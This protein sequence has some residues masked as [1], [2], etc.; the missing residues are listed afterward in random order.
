YKSYHILG[1]PSEFY[2][3]YWHDSK[4]GVASY[5]S[6]DAKRGRKI[7]MWGL[8]RQGMIWEDLLTDKPAGQYVEIQAGR[9]FNQCRGESSFTPFKDRE[10][11]P[12]S[13]DLWT[14]YWMPVLDTGGFNAVS[15]A[16]SMNV[17]VGQN[18]VD[19]AI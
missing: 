6:M 5:L 9:L 4:Y 7:W 17:T 2:G 15:P 8:S 18:K 19:V 13:T 1:A 10:F 3:A 11:A 12:Y 16:A 14:E